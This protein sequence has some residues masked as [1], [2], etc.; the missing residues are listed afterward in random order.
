[1]YDRIHCKSNNT[2]KY[3]KN[4]NKFSKGNFNLK[5]FE[6]KKKKQQNLLFKSMR[7]NGSFA[8]IF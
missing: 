3:N 1:M 8:L 7:I 4:N 5:R 2:T 6:N